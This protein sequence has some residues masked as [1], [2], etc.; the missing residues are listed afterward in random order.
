[1]FQSTGEA[2]NTVNITLSANN[3]GISGAKPELTKRIIGKTNTFT[4]SSYLEVEENLN[5]FFV[6]I[7]GIVSSNLNE[8][9]P[10][11]NIALL[12]NDNHILNTTTD[13]NGRYILK[14]I[15]QGTKTL[16]ASYI[17]FSEEFFYSVRPDNNSKL[18]R[19]FVF[20]SQGI[21]K[22]IKLVK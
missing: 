16:K 10:F 4:N 15:P 8:P 12:K 2:W 18:N 20:N 5:Y 21:L 17:R 19:N 7:A 13:F 22:E 14:P 3:P 6:A 1:V 11:A 9:V